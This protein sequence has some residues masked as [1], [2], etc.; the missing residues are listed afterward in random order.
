LLQRALNER[1]IHDLAFSFGSHG[2]PYLAN[3][4]DIF[5]NLSHA[6][7]RAMCVLSDVEVGCDVEKV[8]KGKTAIAERFFHKDEL[9]MLASL[10]NED[11]KDELFFRFW[12]LK[13][14]LIKASGDGFFLPMV[15]LCCQAKENSLMP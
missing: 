9:R 14:S 5:F 1:G 3:H 4:K 7:E 10:P 8:R 2:K 12:T 6:G 13:E 11:E 15:D